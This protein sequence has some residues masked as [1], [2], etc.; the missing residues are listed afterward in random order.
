MKYV[1]LKS[2]GVSVKVPVNNEARLTNYLNKGFKHV[3]IVDVSEAKA[4]DNVTVRTE[5]AKVELDKIKK[6]VD[7]SKV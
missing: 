6:S 4:I 5:S 2:G 7:K 1:V 3:G